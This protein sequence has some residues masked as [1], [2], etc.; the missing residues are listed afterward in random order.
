MAIKFNKFNVT[1]GATKARVHYC[2]DNRID[3]RTCVTLYAKD[4]GHTLGS[5]LSTA[6]YTNNTDFC[7]DYFEHGKVVLFETHPLYA[8]ARA[9]AERVSR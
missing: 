1:D 3:G 9:T 2:L 4:Y 6:E 7:T 8:A 5:I